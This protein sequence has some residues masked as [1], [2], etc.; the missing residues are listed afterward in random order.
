MKYVVFKKDKMVMPVIFH[1]HINHCDVKIEGWKPVSAGFCSYNTENDYPILIVDYKTFS[2]SLN[3]KP[4]KADGAVL[5]QMI[6]GV[7]IMMF[8]DNENSIYPK[9]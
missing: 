9:V 6:K 1:E 5:N 8:M 3:L 4:N 7:G 2:T